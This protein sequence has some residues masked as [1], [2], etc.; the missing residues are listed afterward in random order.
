M[1]LILIG[2]LMSLLAVSPAQAA[3]PTTASV[4]KLMELTG[5]SEMAQQLLDQIVPH[6]R[7]MTPDAPAEF[8]SDF[9]N[10]VDT[11]AL[12]AKMIPVYQR[13]LDQATVDALVKFYGSPAGQ[14][15]IKAQPTIMAESMKIGEAWGMALGQQI[16]KELQ[17]RKREK[18]NAE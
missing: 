14:A 13:T 2:A 18:A 7:K 17:A 4:Q 12:M 1:R 6:M 3:E 9:R 8:W 10:R 16:A 11:K 5:A 15:F